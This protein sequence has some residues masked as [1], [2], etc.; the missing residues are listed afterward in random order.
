MLGLK[1]ARSW[2]KMLQVQ[3]PVLGTTTCGMCRYRIFVQE[4]VQS[5]PLARLLT[6][7]IVRTSSRNRTNYNLLSDIG[8]QKLRPGNTVTI[9]GVLERGS[10]AGSH[11]LSD[12]VTENSCT[13]RLKQ[14]RSRLQRSTQPLSGGQFRM[15]R[16]SP[17]KKQCGP[18]Y[19]SSV[20]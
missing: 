8:S 9:G 11:L 12:H 18:N 1:V 16:T 10:E 15:G 6:R 20:K 2:S 13:A 4:R 19:R 17:P 14:A 3:M 5:R 7:F